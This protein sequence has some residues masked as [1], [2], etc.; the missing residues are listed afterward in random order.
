MNNKNKIV[1]V[2]F[3][4]VCTFP[5]I[6][7]KVSRPYR[8][9]TVFFLVRQAKNNSALLSWRGYIRKDTPV[10]STQDTD[11]WFHVCR[12]VC[13][14]V[15]VHL[16]HALVCVWVRYSAD[17]VQWAQ[18]REIIT[19]RW[20]L[21][22]SLHNVMRWVCAPWLGV[23]QCW[24]FFLC[25]LARRGSV[26]MLLFLSPPLQNCHLLTCLPCK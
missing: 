13:V 5:H 19:F 1:V 26:L 4:C 7:K 6:S 12:G 11:S 22:T 16:I 21:F 24:C 25:S 14:R 2:K 18:C 17:W 15:C 8:S 23:A 9:S 3:V 10:L 20:Q